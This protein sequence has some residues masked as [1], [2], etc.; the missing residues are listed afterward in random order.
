MFSCV[1]FITISS[2]HWVSSIFLVLKTQGVRQ[3]YPQACWSNTV[4]AQTTATAGILNWGRA[5]KSQ[6]VWM[7]VKFKNTGTGA[8]LS[9]FKSKLYYPLDVW[10]YVATFSHEKSENCLYLLHFTSLLWKLN[11]WMNPCEVLSILPITL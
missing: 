5:Q 6:Q 2:K 3:Q 7:C 1:I 11:K 8:T 10:P 4:K 9:W